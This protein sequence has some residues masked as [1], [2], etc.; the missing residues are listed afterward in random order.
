MRYTDHLKS[1]PQSEPAFGYNQIA[2]NAGGFGFQT[3]DQEQ[4]VRF[5]TLGTEGGTYYVGESKLTQDNAKTIID[6]IKRNGEFVVQTLLQYKSRVPKLDPSLFVLALAATYGNE[7]TKKSAYNAITTLAHT[8]TH[9][10]TLV[11]YLNDLRGWS[12]GLRTGIAQWYNTRTPQ[13]LAY[14]MTKY[15][16][17]NGYTHRDVLRLSHASNSANNILYR[18]AVGKAPSVETGQE[19]IVAFEKAQ[20]AKTVKELLAVMK[21]ANLSWEMIP[22]QFLNEADV[23]SVLL[24]TMPM[25]ATIR[26]LNRFAASGLTKTN[27]SAATKII[28]DRLTDEKAVRESGIHPV[29]VLNAMNVYGQGR[30]DK[31]SL[32]WT[33]NQEIVSSLQDT[34]EIS[35][36][37]VESS[38]KDIILG[39][40]V[41]GSMNTPVGGTSLSAKQVAAAM[42]S[43]TL[44]QEKNVEVI[45]FDTTAKKALVNRKTSYHDIV[46][47]LPNGGGTDLSLPMRWALDNKVKADAIVTYT[48][49]ET[50][51]GGQHPVQAYNEYKK[52][53][54]NNVRAVVVAS[55]ANN[56]DVLPRDGSTLGIAGFDSAVPNLI[57]NFLKGEM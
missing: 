13:Q 46:R 16:Q 9:L 3:T 41:S 17:R 37:N 10:F 8:S 2:N 22:T 45:L 42:M 32:T 25:M 28:R 44:R 27:L 55:S 50:W 11:G 24:Q 21:T 29:F 39:I 1:N 20:A 36:G 56:V 54:N 34:F 49:N 30:G 18:Y 31:G 6:L 53:I 48:D 38:G 19:L 51:S 15:R 7:A 23:L 52:K 35:Y 5:I 4:L 12:R 57:T 33:P 43:V 26:N 40:D 47:A 14:Q